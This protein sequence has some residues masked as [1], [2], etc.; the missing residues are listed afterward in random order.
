[1]GRRMRLEEAPGAEKPDGLRGSGPAGPVPLR[2]GRPGGGGG[3]RRPRSRL[4]GAGVDRAALASGAEG[5]MRL[6]QL[7]SE[8]LGQEVPT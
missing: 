3:G 1:M 2:L 7:L 6:G 5:P 8:R 4:S